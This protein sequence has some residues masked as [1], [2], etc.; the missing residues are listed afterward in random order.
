M[1]VNLFARKRALALL[2]RGMNPDE[3]ARQLVKRHPGHSLEEVKRAYFPSRSSFA[4]GNFTGASR[5]Q[6]LER[7]TQMNAHAERGREHARRINTTP[8]FLEAQ[9]E[10]MRRLNADP[11]FLAAATERIRKF[12]ADP[13]FAKANVDRSRTRMHRLWAPGGTLHGL[14]ANPEIAR[15][16]SEQAREQM[17][18]LNADPQFKKANAERSSER[19]RKLHQDPQFAKANAQRA[20]EIMRR[21]WENPLFRKKL[22]RG[23]SRYWANYR[24]NLIDAMEQMGAEHGGYTYEEETG[25]RKGAY[26]GKIK[27]RIATTSPDIVENRV[28]ERE[29]RQVINE[30]LKQ[31]TKQEYQ[32][33]ATMFGF[34][35]YP[36]LLD[37]SDK[38]VA[39]TLQ[40]ALKKLAQN[41]QLQELH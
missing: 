39:K 20:R 21:L 22:S 37:G 10:R 27:T 12:N 7:I 17:R 9:S 35:D 1:K 6:I 40:S 19:M 38:Q 15:L 3:V 4:I 5:Q 14:W 31:L 16:M 28:L 41:K 36:I 32:T 34:N 2:G 33:I 13:K 8:G 24:M 18:K 23:L 26:G 11:K 25:P 30:A 29:R